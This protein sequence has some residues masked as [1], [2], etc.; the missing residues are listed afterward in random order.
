MSSGQIEYIWEADATAS[1]E[2]V[3]YLDMQQ[4][5]MADV[6]GAI[7]ALD[8]AIQQ[9]E[10]RGEITREESRQLA[11]AMYKAK[12]IYNIYKHT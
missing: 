8:R 10:A 12:A 6:E 1:L 2:D 9:A 7:K 3:D 11:E 4:A 5:N